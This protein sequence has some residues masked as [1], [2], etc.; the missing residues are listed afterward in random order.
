M[1][2]VEPLYS[3]TCCQRVSTFFV[4]VVHSE[5]NTSFCHGFITITSK[6][7]TNPRITS[8]EP[9]RRLRYYNNV[10]RSRRK[11]KHEDTRIIADYPVRK[12]RGCRGLRRICEA[13]CGQGTWVLRPIMGST[14]T[15]TL[16][17]RTRI[18]SRPKTAK[19]K[20]N[21]PHPASSF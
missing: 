15:R 7:R 13:G 18:S 2:I 5:L 8:M 12:C 21:E 10:K 1:I 6:D 20:H 9:I 3:P 14:P 11:N 4:L 16:P 17:K 19:R